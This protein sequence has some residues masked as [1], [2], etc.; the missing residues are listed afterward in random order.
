MST[1][2]H[3]SFLGDFESVTPFL[4]P[5]THR[6]VVVRKNG[7]SESYSHCP[8]LLKERWEIH[9]TKKRNICSPWHI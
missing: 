3:E 2:S 9:L 4:S 8:E 6:I 5:L 7:T 1:L